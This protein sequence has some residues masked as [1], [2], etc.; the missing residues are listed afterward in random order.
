[1]SQADEIGDQIACLGRESIAAPSCPLV[2]LPLQPGERDRILRAW[3]DTASDGEGSMVTLSWTPPAGSEAPTGYLI[4]AG[5]DPGLSDIATILVGNVT[6]LS[7]E[8][9]PGTYFVRVRAINA[10]GP[11]LPSNEVVVQK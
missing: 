8:A 6:T 9:P 11:G 10:L 7:T 2:D 3:H 5:R 4:E 1:M